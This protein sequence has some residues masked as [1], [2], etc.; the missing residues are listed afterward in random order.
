MTPWIKQSL[1]GLCAATLIAGAASVYADPQ[2]QGSHRCS[3][4]WMHD[5][6]ARAEFRAK[7]MERIST[8]LGLNDTQKQK[9]STFFD[10]LSDQRKA[11]MGDGKG[12]HEKLQSLIAG[13]TFDRDGAQALLN[14]KVARLQS[15]GPELIAAAADF[16]DSLSAEQQ[17]KAREFLE[18]RHGRR[19]HRPKADQ[20]Q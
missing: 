2:G 12:R 17:Q 6:E 5:D 8:E 19:D 4:G 7:R 14:E 1:V 3:K 13:K 10:K 11:K 16:F 15:S 9:L 18:R 20:A